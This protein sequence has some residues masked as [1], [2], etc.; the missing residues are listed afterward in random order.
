MYSAT[1]AAFP[2]ANQTSIVRSPMRQLISTTPN[3]WMIWI[4]PASVSL[5]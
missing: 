1:E 2:G 4:S 3:L 5:R